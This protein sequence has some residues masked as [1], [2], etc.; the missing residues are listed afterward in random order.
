MSEDRNEDKGAGKTVRV[1]TN[2]STRKPEV[3][4]SSLGSIL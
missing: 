3:V 1:K 4:A 2:E